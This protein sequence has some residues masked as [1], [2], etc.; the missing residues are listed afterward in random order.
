V[1]WLSDAAA[2]NSSVIHSIIGLPRENA[3]TRI[4]GDLRGM[5]LKR[6]T[7]SAKYITTSETP[8]FQ[9][10]IYLLYARPKPP[11]YNHHQTQHNILKPP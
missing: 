1:I 2:R 3:E 10:V 8:S 9:H 6:M 5:L 4:G 7:P 11:I